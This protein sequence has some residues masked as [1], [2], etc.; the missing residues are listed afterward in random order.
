M[1]T[2]GFSIIFVLGE[3]DDIRLNVP[4]DQ[5][6]IADELARVSRPHPPFRDGLDVSALKDC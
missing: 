6:R 3:L 4:R 1:A 2:R 5:K